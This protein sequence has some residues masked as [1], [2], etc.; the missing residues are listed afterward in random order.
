MLMHARHCTMMHLTVLLM[1]CAAC[2]LSSQLTTVSANYFMTEKE[3][4]RVVHSVIEHH[5]FTPPL[6]QSYY[7]DG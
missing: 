7:G 3:R 6:L 5:S 2:I 4:Q 1:V